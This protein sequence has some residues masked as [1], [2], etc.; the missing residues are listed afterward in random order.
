MCTGVHLGNLPPYIHGMKVLPS[1]MNDIMALELDIEY[2][3]GAVLDIETR[4]EVCG[5][6]I[7]ENMSSNLDPTSVDE[8][9]SDLLE[10]IEHY[11]NQF[12]LSKGEADKTEARNEGNPK[13]GSSM[14]CFFSTPVTPCMHYFRAKIIYEIIYRLQVVGAKG[15]YPTQNKLIKQ[16]TLTRK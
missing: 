7:S 12:K 3:G 13:F 2:R 5:I 8:V 4:V 6:D 14:I 9:T 16:T 10:G 15:V 11:G 1:D